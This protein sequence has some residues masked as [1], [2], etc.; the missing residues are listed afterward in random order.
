MTA[1]VLA[2]TILSVQALQRRNADPAPAVDAV[3]VAAREAANAVLRRVT[4][5]LRRDPLPESTPEVDAM[6]RERARI[7]SRITASETPTGAP[8]GDGESALERISRRVDQDLRLNA[9]RESST[10]LFRRFGSTIE[11][12]PSTERMN[13]IN[14]QAETIATRAVPTT[15]RQRLAQ[16]EMRRAEAFRA[17]ASANADLASAAHAIEEK[18]GVAERL[19]SENLAKEAELKEVDEAGTD[20][21]REATLRTNIAELKRQIA[22]VE[23]EQ[24][25]AEARRE[26]L[27]DR[28]KEAQAE[29]AKAEAE[30]KDV[31]A[32]EPEVKPGPDIEMARR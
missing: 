15:L 20:P 32:K 19:K 22:R 23:R 14:E 13:I 10:Q 5:M 25:A 6:L 8:V 2:A 17:V 7:T 29:A 18:Q 16:V 1:L 31:E 4:E 26:A 24:E 21:A 11:I 28:V 27:E 12:L 30:A 3:G 9:A